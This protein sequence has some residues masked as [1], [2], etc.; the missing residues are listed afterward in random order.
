[1]HN[2]HALFDFKDL[3]WKGFCTC[4]SSGFTK[5]KL[6]YSQNV[7]YFCVPPAD[8]QKFDLNI[9]QLTLMIN[10]SCLTTSYVN[11]VPANTH[12]TS[13]AKYSTLEVENCDKNV[14]EGETKATC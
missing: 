5:L 7:A 12:R 14:R 13:L 1:M 6:I 2:C 10:V 8:N 3:Y 4:Y 11:L 9:F